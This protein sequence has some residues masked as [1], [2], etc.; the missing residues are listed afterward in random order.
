[1]SK[2]ISVLR[3]GKECYK[4]AIERDFNNL[5]SYIQ[6]ELSVQGRK[7]CIVTDTN[8][9]P[10]YADEV[11]ACLEGICKS[12]MVYTMTAGEENKTLDVVKDIYKV[13]IDNHFDRKDV[14]FALGGGVVGDLTGYTAATYLRGVDFVQ[15]PTT[16]LSQTDSS[17]GGKTGVDFD[18]YKNM[19]GA[20]HMPKLVY[21]NMSTLNTLPDRQFASGMAEVLKHGIIKNARF[22]E[23]LIDKFNEINDKEPDVL[24]EMIYESCLVK[25][26]VV[27]KDPTEQGDRALLNFG[28]TLGHAIEKY[29]NFSL[30][31]GECVALGCIC[32]ALISYKR[33]LIS[34][35]E[36]FEIRDMFMPF[37]LPISIDEIDAKE[38]IKLT[39]S[40]KKADGN[41]VRF[42]LLKK[43]GKA[44]IDRTVTEEEM[45]YALN[46][47]DFDYDA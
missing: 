34:A 1:M 26:E 28:H 44:F 40:D 9:G 6:S 22:Y 18:S 35:E 7:I 10:L 39:K 21:M 27:E 38:I 45:L 19:V 25:K 41:T 23:W 16:L 32:A 8:V 24:E 5:K 30:Y 36:C 4:I 20:F 29:K 46:E 33:Q 14:L 17:I 37:N 2:K 15:I 47:I 43:I 3:D 42:I 11:K 31:H 13:L 12:V